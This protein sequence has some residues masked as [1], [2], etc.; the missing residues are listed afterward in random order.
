MQDITVG[1]GY[2]PT[3][4]ALWLAALLALGTVVFA[5]APPAPFA[6][7]QVPPF[8]PLIYT[9]N[10]LLPVVAFGQARAYDP[11]GPEQWLSYVLIA[12]GWTLATAVAAGIIRVLQR[13]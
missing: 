3:R 1:Y 9:L 13:D 4:A 11:R 5:I 2:R 8:N 10:L 7:T 12:A 6:G